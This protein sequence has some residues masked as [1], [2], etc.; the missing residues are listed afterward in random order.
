MLFE[1]CLT[2][3]AQ[4]PG[5]M[6][7]AEVYRGLRDDDFRVLM[8][9]ETGMRFYEWVPLEELPKFTRVPK[10]KVQYILGRLARLKLIQRAT[11]PYEGYRIYF[12]AYDL[13]AINAFVKRDTIRALGDVIGVGKESEVYS[14]VGVV[15]VAVKFHREGRTSFKQV[16]RVRVHLADREHFSW[17][18]AARLAATREY[19]AMKK[20]YP[21]VS[22]PEPIDHNRHAIVMS[23]LRGSELSNTKL[24][25]PEWFLDEILRQIRITYEMGIVHADL[26]EYNVYV[27]P[28]GVEII[29]W[30]QYVEV[31]Q[32]NAAE[33]L[34]RD[35]GNILAYFRRKYGLSRDLE[36]T[37]E[38]IMA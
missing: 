21:R 38:S 3:P 5:R 7:K 6:N 13:L 10:D 35:V 32:P 26:S 28:E 24:L 9:I 11:Q 34:R 16:K 17:I 37:L 12:D 4:Y 27:N 8:G 22:V 15:P 20:L 1:K 18:Y 25:D 19:A 2:S 36:S 31:S 14:A 29:D 23:V 30:P 33:L